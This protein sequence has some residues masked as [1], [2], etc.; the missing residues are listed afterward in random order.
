MLTSLILSQY[1]P[2]HLFF[3]FYSI[4]PPTSLKP[5]YQFF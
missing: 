5:H 2:G 4:Q 3:K 1:I